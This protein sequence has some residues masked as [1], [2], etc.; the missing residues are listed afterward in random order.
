MSSNVDVIS[1]G[2]YR[3]LKSG[4]GYDAFI[5]GTNCKVTSLSSGDTFT[6][7]K[8]M[9]DW[10]NKHK[11]QTI[12]LAPGLRGKSL[13]ATAQNIYRFLYD[14]IQ[15]RA[16]GDMQ[17]LKS[18]GCTWATR[19]EG[20]DCKTFSIFASSILSNL[21]IQH[22]IRQVTQPG[23]YPDQY[24]HVYVVIPRNQKLTKLTNNEKVFVIDATRHQNIE[25]DF[26][27]K[28]DTLMLH[29][30]LS[31]PAAYR[32]PATKKRARGLNGVAVSTV[33][34]DLT[35]LLNVLIMAGVPQSQMKQVQ[36][37]AV[38]YLNQGLDPEFKINT[39][40]ITVGS[41]TI[42]FFPAGLKAP[43][44][45]FDPVT[46]GV[47]SQAA[48]SGGGAGDAAGVMSGVLEGLNIK[49]N[50][51]LVT[52]YG[53][54]SWGASGSPE[55]NAEHWERYTKPALEQL[56]NNLSSYKNIQF[57]LNKLQAFVDIFYSFVK[58][59][60]DNHS[61]ARSTREGNQW[62]MDTIKQVES[63][64]INPLV[65]KLK[66]AGIQV[67]TYT[68]DPQANAF[69]VPFDNRTLTNSNPDRYLPSSVKQYNITVPQSLINE[70]TGV[71]TNLPSGE[72][73]AQGNQFGSG[74]G[75]GSSTGG[76]TNYPTT[77]NYTTG[78]GTVGSTTATAGGISPG[79]ILLVAAGA[80]LAYT[81]LNKK[82]KSTTTAKTKK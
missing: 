14:H 50:I 74:S 52:K 36:D 77:G 1:A 21:G 38:S 12:L 60:R 73:L 69:R 2:L 27:K 62:S 44:L 22:S 10:V 64:V 23:Y 70:A 59:L 40:S 28:H 42:P 26:I 57:D 32:R 18:P 48:G 16:D 37:E 56:V 29:Q 43:G 72:E 11:E 19:K 13:A 66:A 63:Q 47:I 6:T 68:A 24:T 45:G 80:G 78:N 7:V 81:Q 67:S 20:A 75:S 9:R 8:H 46:I 65:S 25:V 5:K 35:D 41:K 33:S 15:Y 39:D 51:A 82:K 3:P 30:G 58:G 4:K 79:M 61:K 55:R 49:Q 54:S 76:N 53:L 34:R 71:N 31:S 17:N